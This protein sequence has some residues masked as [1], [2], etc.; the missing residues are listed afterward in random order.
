MFQ[1]LQGIRTTIP[2]TGK[3]FSDPDVIHSLPRGQEGTIVHVYSGGAAYEVEFVLGEPGPDGFIAH[4]RY[5]LLAI[6]PQH[7]EA[8]A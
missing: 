7:L 3:D 2:L 8:A 6:E 1:E 5:C 4:P